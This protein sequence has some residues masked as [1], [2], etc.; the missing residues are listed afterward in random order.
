[1]ENLGCLT[2]CIY[3]LEKTDSLFCFKSGPL[4]SKCS[5]GNISAIG[6]FQ[7]II[8]M[9]QTQT[10]TDDATCPSGHH[11]IHDYLKSSGR[12]PPN[13]PLMDPK[14]KQMMMFQFLVS[15]QL[16]RQN[17]P[18]KSQHW[19]PAPAHSVTS[20]AALTPATQPDFEAKFSFRKNITRF[21][22]MP[23][24]IFKGRCMIIEILISW[25]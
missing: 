4:E 2:R 10:L 12:A 11:S 18:D 9:N 16:Q 22:F 21:N 20:S 14:S 19:S 3:K 25:M 23:I 1:M 15:Q 8:Q 6:K 17:F 13:H 7:C 24:K 5:A